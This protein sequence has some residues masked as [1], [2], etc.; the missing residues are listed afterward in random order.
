MY[1]FQNPSWPSQIHCYLNSLSAIPNLRRFYGWWNVAI[2]GWILIVLAIHSAFD[3]T[4]WLWCCWT[5]VFAA[6]TL[7]QN[8]GTER[9]NIGH[10]VLML[11]IQWW[12]LTLFT[13]TLCLIC[14][15]CKHLQIIF[16]KFPLSW[17]SRQI[18]VS[19]PYQHVLLVFSLLGRC[20]H[21]HFSD[22]FLP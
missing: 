18:S 4:V 14:I 20:S 13:D 11:Q 1:R 8:W 2:L 10:S 7:L 16:M 22:F 3:C 21:F 6:Q 9:R 5:S 15:I 19:R 17:S 12:D